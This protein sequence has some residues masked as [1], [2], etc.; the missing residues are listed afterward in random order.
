MHVDKIIEPTW[1]SLSV[2]TTAFRQD[3]TDTTLS[4]DDN[5]YKER[6]SKAQFVV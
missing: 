5:E 3:H 4:R 2:L 1:R 6:T